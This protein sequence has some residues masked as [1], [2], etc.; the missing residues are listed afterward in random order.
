MIPF[1][2]AFKKYSEQQNLPKEVKG[3][4]YKYL[5]MPKNVNWRKKKGKFGRIN[6]L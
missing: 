6:I 4:Y 5:K 1:I 3:L 2:I